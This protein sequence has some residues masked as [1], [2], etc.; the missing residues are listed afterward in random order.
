MKV[1]LF[2]LILIFQFSNETEEKGSSHYYMKS[3]NIEELITLKNDGSGF[4]ISWSNQN[5]W[6]IDCQEFNYYEYDG[7]YVFNYKEEKLKSDTIKISKTR[8]HLSL[9][10]TSEK[11][12]QIEF[13]C[14][15]KSRLSRKI[16]SYFWDLVF[17]E[18]L[19]EGRS[20]GG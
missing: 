14:H 4:F 11:L 1:V 10:G 8:K 15:S 16:P 6:W 18:F 9:K 2:S 19:E 3:N 17:E 5:Y 20:C 12:F 7:F 13:K